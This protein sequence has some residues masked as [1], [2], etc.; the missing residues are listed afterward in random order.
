M[1]TLKEQVRN[2]LDALELHY[3]VNDEKC[4][5]ELD[6]KMEHTDVSINLVYDEEMMRLFCF[7]CLTFCLPKE[8]SGEI[9]RKINE[10]HNGSFSLAHLYL[11][12]EDN[13]LAAQSAMDVTERGLDEEQFK[14][15]LA[16]TCELLEE[17]FEAIM[18][19]AYGGAPGAGKVDKPVEEGDEENTDF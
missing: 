10:I 2:A 18:A 13:R 8:R 16:S 15:F 11:G 5:F 17:N 14:Y 9:L 6:M 3:G 1:G 19:V 12:T 4:R 7:S